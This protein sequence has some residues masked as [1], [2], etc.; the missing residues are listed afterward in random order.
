V[1]LVALVI[2]VGL[3]LA[4]ELSA[5][6][7]RARIRAGEL[8]AIA[9][10]ASRAAASLNQGIERIQGQIL[11]A[12]ETPVSG[13]RTPLLAA[14]AGADPPA[15]LALLTYLDRI[16]SPSEQLQRL[17]LLDRDGRI[18]VAEPPLT[19]PRL[20]HTYS[21]LFTAVS[22]AS[23]AY[24]SGVYNTEPA[25]GGG[26]GGS[27][28]DAPVIGISGLIQ[29]HGSRLGVLVAEVNLR[30]LGLQM[31]PVLGAAD[32]LYLIDNKGGLL[33]RATHAFVGDSAEGRDLRDTAAG[34][35]ALAGVTR[36]EGADPVVG[37]PRLVG[38]ARVGASGLRVIAVRAPTAM[39]PELD[40]SLTVNRAAGIA[41][42]VVLILGIALLAP[43]AASISTAARAY[44]API[45]G[46]GNSVNPSTPGVR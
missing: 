24:V 26:M 7:A 35:A 9:G 38:T 8:E 18:L 3:L 42:V 4:G 29:E 6:E 20:D 37:G 5:L 2:G 39:D 1:L 27:S 25:P 10:A 41:L 17:I 16:M 45:D 46:P 15:T 11:S 19:R 22:D 14:L 12:T 30:L 34:G 31:T 32:D 28:N 44:D 36:L 33:L 40:A 23:P 13:R 43:R 21:D